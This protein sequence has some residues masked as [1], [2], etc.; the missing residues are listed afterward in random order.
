MAKDTFT[1]TDDFNQ[2]Y[3]LLLADTF[4]QFTPAKIAAKIEV[5][6]GVTPEAPNAL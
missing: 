1:A 4:G 2:Q 3:A 6:T 5:S